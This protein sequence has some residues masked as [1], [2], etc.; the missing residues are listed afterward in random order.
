MLLSARD[1]LTPRCIVLQRPNF[2]HPASCQ[3]QATS[4]P[5]VP[6]GT[7]TRMG[8]TCVHMHIFASVRLPSLRVTKINRVPHPC[9]C[10]T[11]DTYTRHVTIPTLRCRW[12]HPHGP[13]T[14]G[15]QYTLQTDHAETA[16]H[17][18]AQHPHFYVMSQE[19]PAHVAFRLRAEYHQA[20]A[21][22]LRH[23]STE[24]HA[25]HIFTLSRCIC[26]LAKIA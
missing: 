13:R 3:H 23:A 12:A 17:E 26:T 14:I 18:C 7:P 9:I 15:S 21:R 10:A 8:R 1:G 2:T 11:P 6:S 25:L 16:E 20:A 19:R 22:T 5:N 24:E 4:P